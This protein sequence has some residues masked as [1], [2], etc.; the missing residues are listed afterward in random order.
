M[1]LV[2]WRV[3]FC[4][5]G[6]VFALVTGACAVTEKGGNLAS[7]NVNAIH[8]RETPSG[9]GVQIAVTLDELQVVSCTRLD[10]N[11]QAI[12]NGRAAD[13]ISPGGLETQKFSN[14]CAPPEATWTLT[15]ADLQ[16][17]GPS[18]HIEFFDSS[19]RFTFDAEAYL[20]FRNDR[21]IASPCGDLAPLPP[22]LS[23]IVRGS[24]VALATEP[25]TP[26][27]TDAA[28][29]LEQATLPDGGVDYYQPHA[30]LPVETGVTGTVLTIQVPASTPLGRYVLTASADA[31]LP[32][33]RCSPAGVQCEAHVG[34]SAAFPVEIVGP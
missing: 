13:A 30:L 21:C 23:P 25:A 24:T 29:S 26:G 17:L 27:L 20:L 14:A 12:L 19:K 32:S 4:L 8:V 18:L 5:A 1:P 22:P 11:P 34:F 10:S 2:P 31:K 15:A 28:A 9:E 7:Y 16:V 6:T 3:S 33:V